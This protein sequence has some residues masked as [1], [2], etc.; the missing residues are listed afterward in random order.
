MIASSLG[1]LA[2]PARAEAYENVRLA[3]LDRVIM[4]NWQGGETWVDAWREASGSLA[5]DFL[6][7]VSA[8]LEEAASFSRYPASRLAAAQPTETDRER[9]LQQLLA[10]G[11]ELERLES[12]AAGS[13]IDRQRG[14]ALESAWER[15]IGVL[16]RERPRWEG[17]ISAVR[18]WQRPWG[19]LLLGSVPVLCIALL[20]ASWLGGWI[21]AP[22]WFAPVAGA[23][24]S[25][26]WP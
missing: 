25:V 13:A 14:A 18:A 11:F 2:A 15:A 19:P 6:T 9:L 16:Q 17:E 8:A 5:A 4:G 23:F 22:E 7:S 12:S 24:W 20:I 3:L 21:A 10:E 1:R 26:P